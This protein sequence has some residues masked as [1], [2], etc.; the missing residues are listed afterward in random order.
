[1]IAPQ[2]GLLKLQ[3][4]D[5]WSIQS[6]AVLVDMK[7]PTRGGN[8]SVAGLPH[9]RIYAKR[10]RD[11]WCR[12]TCYFCFPEGLLGLCAGIKP[13]SQRNIF[14]CVRWS[15]SAV[16][17]HVHGCKR[18]IE[19]MTKDSTQKELHCRG[20]TRLCINTDFTCDLTRHVF[21]VC[22]AKCKVCD[23]KPAARIWIFYFKLP[24]QPLWTKVCAT[25]DGH[26]SLYELRSHKALRMTA[27]V[28]HTNS[29]LDI[30][31]ASRLISLFVETP[32]VW[33]D[34]WHI[35]VLLRLRLSL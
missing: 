32:F 29:E 19:N 7:R 1:M 8:T 33:T 13:W 16:L 35:I 9:V 3:S 10:V 21:M 20:Y 26:H 28:V 4:M 6:K 30:H 12:A 22:C 23:C 31:K 15:K 25:T 11:E 14:L 2:L 24:L 34:D 5:F 18:M 17:S 27:V